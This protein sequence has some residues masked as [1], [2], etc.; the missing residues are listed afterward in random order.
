MFRCR[1]ASS[2][3]S[4]AVSSAA[5]LVGRFFAD[6]DGFA[7]R[8]QLLPDGAQFRVG[9]A[10][11]VVGADDFHRFFERVPVPGHEPLQQDRDRAERVGRRRRPPAAPAF[12][13]EIEQLPF[14]HGGQIRPHRA[15]AAKLAQHCAVV[16]EQAHVDDA[17]QSLPVQRTTGD[18]AGRRSVRCARSVRGCRGTAV[19]HPREFWGKPARLSVRLIAKHKHSRRNS[20]F[21]ARFRTGENLFA[22]VRLYS[23]VTKG[24]DSKVRGMTPVD[25]LFRQTSS[26]RWHLA[27]WRD[28]RELHTFAHVRRSA[29][30]CARRGRE[31]G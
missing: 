7:A 3:R 5:H 25:H 12:V 28:L 20:T 13:D 30:P 8:W 4:S 1:S 22:R 26:R 6:F 29:R 2:T 21:F 31:A 17:R 19:V 11:L 24:A 15:L 10:D 27:N 23:R 9:L 16:L 18:D 14:D